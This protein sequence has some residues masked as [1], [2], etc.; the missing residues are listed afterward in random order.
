MVFTL[1]EI[2]PCSANMGSVRVIFLETFLFL[3]H[4]SI[5]Y[6]GD[7]FDKNSYSIHACWM[8]L[9]YP[10]SRLGPGL[11]VYHLLI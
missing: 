10:T 11:A 9:S 3:F 2:I 6:V 5:L 1:G 7:I 8:R 4:F